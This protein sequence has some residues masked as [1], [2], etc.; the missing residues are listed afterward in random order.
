MIPFSM[1]YILVPRCSKFPNL[2]VREMRG[3]QF[4]GQHDGGVIGFLHMQSFPKLEGLSK[5]HFGM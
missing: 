1:M 4:G 3:L 5:K 2:I